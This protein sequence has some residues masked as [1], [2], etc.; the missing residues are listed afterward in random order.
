MAER[1]WD[2]TTVSSAKVSPRFVVMLGLMVNAVLLLGRAFN[3][4]A[5]TL[6]SVVLKGSCWS[7]L[8]SPS[9]SSWLLR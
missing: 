1:Y 2:E 9:L 7:R 6:M 8:L 5:A 3:N 4:D